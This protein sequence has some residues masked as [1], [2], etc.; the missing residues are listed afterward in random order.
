V[1]SLKDWSAS[2]FLPKHMAA[3][4]DGPAATSAKA[5]PLHP[6]STVLSVTTAHHGAVT[7]ARYTSECTQVQMHPAGTAFSSDFWRPKCTQQ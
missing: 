3:G 5:S 4:M 7:P 2:F 6:S 1:S